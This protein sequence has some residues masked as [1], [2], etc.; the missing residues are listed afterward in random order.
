MW[1]FKLDHNMFATREKMSEHFTS[2]E[3]FVLKISMNRFYDCQIEY[4]YMTSKTIDRLAL[5]KGELDNG[6]CYV[7]LPYTFPLKIHDL[8]HTFKRPSILGIALKTIFINK[9][10]PPYHNFVEIL[11]HIKSYSHKTA[12][13]SI[14]EGFNKIET[15]LA[16]AS[17]LDLS[18]F[19][20]HINNQCFRF[21]E[22][23]AKKTS[24]FLITNDI[25]EALRT[26]KYGY[27]FKLHVCL[28][29]CTI[30]VY[31]C[32]DNAVDPFLSHLAKRE[33]LSAFL[34]CKDTDYNPESVAVSPTLSL[35]SSISQEQQQ[36]LG[37]RAERL[38]QFVQLHFIHKHNTSY[39][40]CNLNKTYIIQHANS[41][42]KC[43]RGFNPHT[44]Q[45]DTSSTLNGSVH[46]EV[47]ESILKVFKYDFKKQNKASIYMCNMCGYVYW[48]GEK[49]LSKKKKYSRKLM[50]LDEQVKQQEDQDKED[51]KGTDIEEEQQQHQQRQ[52]GN[53][54]KVKRK[55]KNDTGEKEKERR[56]R[57][58]SNSA[59]KLIESTI[60][61]T[62][63]N[64]LM[65][66]YSKKTKYKQMSFLADTLR[67][68]CIHGCERFDGPLMQ[69]INLIDAMGRRY[70]IAKPGPPYEFTVCAA[71]RGCNV[72]FKNNKKEY[73][74]C[75][76]CQLIFEN[77]QTKNAKHYFLFKF[78]TCL[79]LKDQDPCQGCINT[80]R[81]YNV[82]L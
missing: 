63:K 10:I 70:S 23:E 41:L 21:K 42:F 64:N 56:K 67:M 14:Q 13:G 3:S 28:M 34:P 9:S 11:H 53:S 50:E 73:P 47:E 79:M 33:L 52:Q 57:K 36:H 15:I 32:C 38:Y 81:F 76:E 20:N 8:L 18:K 69:H 5:S 40:H 72:V 39:K 48:Y 1:G 82:L 19:I 59:D 66:K 7:M 74:Y 54:S 26:K 55:Y 37:Y 58:K 61:K 30:L 16:H 29:V 6:T 75:T 78:N 44:Y 62:T 51:D 60:F 35:L 80:N 65:V 45:H 77:L 2:K 68:K 27:T 31:I 46:R 71:S 17:K 22:C 24:H 43:T 49:I 12:N 4:N 25:E